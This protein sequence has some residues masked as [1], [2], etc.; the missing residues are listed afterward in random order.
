MKSTPMAACRA[1][2]WAG[3]I[4]KRTDARSKLLGTVQAPLGAIPHANFVRVI[5]G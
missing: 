3:W 4:C 5:P 1:A 2:E